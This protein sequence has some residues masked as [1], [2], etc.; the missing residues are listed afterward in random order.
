MKVT[1]IMNSYKES[2]RLFKR[3]I[4]SIPDNV[5]R[6]I[7]LSTVE[8][9]P[10]IDWAKKYNDITIV[11]TKEPGIT[12]QLNNAIDSVDGDYVCYC[13][14]NDIMYPNKLSLETEILEET[15]KKVCNSSFMV[16]GK[17]IKQLPSQYDYAKHLAGNYI[18]DCSM[19][20]A[21]TFLKY[22]PFN[23]KYYELQYFDLWLRIYEGEGD[24]FIY[25]P[26]PTWNYCIS[27]RSRSIKRKKSATLKSKRA[28]EYRMLIKNRSTE[29]LS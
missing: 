17:K 26:I 10:C 3:A 4:E 7:V 23:E 29:N 20:E 13:S 5:N 2:K 1:I 16:N 22:M 12:R 28:E 15:G 27:R 6:S 19:V 25:N 9:D 14:S 21:K 8:G 18:S 11:T 24:V